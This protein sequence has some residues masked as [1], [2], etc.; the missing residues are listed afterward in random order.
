[1]PVESWKLIKHAL[2]IGITFFDTANMYSQGSSEEILGQALK[3]YAKR[4]DVVMATKVR[5]PIRS[6][7]NG[8]GLSRK[9]IM[10]EPEPTKVPIGW[11]R[12][13]K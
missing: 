3:D 7:P 6:G 4:D 8:K 12:T 2:D 13:R 1:M 10:T 9:A 5:H 11:K